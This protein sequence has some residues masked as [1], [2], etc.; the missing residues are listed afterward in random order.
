M[1]LDKNPLRACNTVIAS[2]ADTFQAAES[3][4]SKVQT[5]WKVP[6][7]KIKRRS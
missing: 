6:S 2:L 4:T 7:M 3:V 5:V 1:L